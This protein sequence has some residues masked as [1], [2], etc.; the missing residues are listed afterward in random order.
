V[1]TKTAIEQVKTLMVEV[2]LCT[3]KELPIPEIRSRSGEIVSH[4][5]VLVRISNLKLAFPEWNFYTRTC[6]QTQKRII[7]AKLTEAV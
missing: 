2:L 4:E 1:T 6:Q 5:S 7:G 3:E